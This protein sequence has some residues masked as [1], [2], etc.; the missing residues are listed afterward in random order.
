MEKRI[1]ILQSN[2][3]PWRGYFDIIASVDEFLIYDSA[4][5]T[6]NDWRNR[7]R[8]KTANGPTWLTIPVATAGQFNQSIAHAR[9]ANSSWAAKH[10]RTLSQAY[11]KAPY[12]PAYRDL[13]A[14]VYEACAGQ[15]LLSDINRHLLS[16]IVSALGLTTQIADAPE[17]PSDNNPTMRLIDICLAV[18]A[19]TYLSGP[20]AKNYMDISL[21]DAV[22]ITVEFMDYSK[23][24]PY[25]QLHGDFYP[26]VSILD[27][28]FSV[29]PQARS[30]LTAPIEAFEDTA[31]LISTCL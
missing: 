25:P 16:T 10:W 14:E 28:L 24:R 8:I 17:L 23:Y 5:Y 12:F 1:A 21:F 3:I 22:G 30:Y 9:C 13:L 31:E 20:S 19:T 4:Q 26:A 6:K 29:G 18:G 2:Y 15:T 11:A 7:N 27:L